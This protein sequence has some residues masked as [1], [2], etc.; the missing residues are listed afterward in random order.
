MTLAMALI[1]LFALRAGGLSLPSH[2]DPRY[3]VRLALGI[4]ALAGGVYMARRKPRPRGDTGVAAVRALPGPAGG[5][6]PA[7]QGVQWLAARA[8]A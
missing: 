2:H 5:H 3:G 7:A 8:R 6:H 4:L 1:V